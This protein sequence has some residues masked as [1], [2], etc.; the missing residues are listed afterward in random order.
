MNALD[1]GCCARE[2]ERARRSESTYVVFPEPAVPATLVLALATAG[3]EMLSHGF[4]YERLPSVQLADVDVLRRHDAG[5]TG[6]EL[7]PSRRLVPRVAQFPK[8]AGAVSIY[9]GDKNAAMV[10]AF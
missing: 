5:L 9:Y 3:K 1:G 8:P 2:W 6:D 4:V 10:V 7:S